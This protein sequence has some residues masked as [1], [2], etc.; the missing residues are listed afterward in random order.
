LKQGSGKETKLPLLPGTV[1]QRWECSKT[2]GAEAGFDSVPAHSLF[3]I[4]ILGF[5]KEAAHKNETN[6][7]QVNQN[8][9]EHFC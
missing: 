5:T 8:L 4:N 7:S 6:T 2:C 3:E 1:T 9:I